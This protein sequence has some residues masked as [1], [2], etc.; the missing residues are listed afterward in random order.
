MQIDV[1]CHR[2]RF[3]R[4]HHFQ[5]PPADL[6]TLKRIAITNILL[7]QQMLDT[8]RRRGIKTPQQAIGR[9]R[10]VSI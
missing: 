6:Q 3:A 5:I 4:P 1:P 7:D 8:G 2:F 9:Y 10:Q